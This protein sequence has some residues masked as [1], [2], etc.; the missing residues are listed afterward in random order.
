MKQLQIIL[1]IGVVVVGGGILGMKLFKKN[2]IAVVQPISDDRVFVEIPWEHLPDVAEFKLTERSGKKFSS[3]ELAGKPYALNIFFAS[4]PTI[5]YDFNK[6]IRSL[7]NKYRKQTDM[8]FVSVTCDPGKDTPEVLTRY[9]DGLQ[10]DKKRWLFLTGPNYAIR[11]LGEQSFRVVVDPANHTDDIMLVDRWG[12]YRDRFKWNDPREIKRFDTV[13]KEVL[14][15]TKPPIGK[16]IRTRNVLAAKE[17]FD[18]SK[19]PFLKDFRLTTSQ[20]REFFS[21][22]MTGKVWVASFFFTSCNGIC[23][24]QNKKLSEL[25]NRFKQA[26]VHLVSISTD[27]AND[28]PAKLRIYA[29]DLRANPHAWTF[30]TGT[31][32]DYI[33]RVMGEYLKLHAHGEHHS[34]ELVLIDRWGKPRKSFD[35]KDESQIDQ[36]FEMAAKLAKEQTP[37]DSL[38]K[39]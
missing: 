24:R 25:Q 12:R 7:S 37:A 27:P 4:C 20:G 14:A 31:D 22:D 19:I 18:P 8:T 1:W 16:V 2:K 17:T 28:T 36:L 21:R 32:Q 38:K 29:N 30:L 6:T 5:C 13:L 15:E 10:A 11:E 9:A 39:D 23:P 3:N 26:N 33:N 34:S 35:W